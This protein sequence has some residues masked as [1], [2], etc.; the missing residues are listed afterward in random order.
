M[1]QIVIVLLV[2]A[3][4]LI[5]VIRHYVKVFRSEAP[6]CTACSGSC[7]IKPGGSGTTPVETCCEQPPK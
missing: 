7:A 3:V 2:V 1:T 4:V 6:A 5:Y